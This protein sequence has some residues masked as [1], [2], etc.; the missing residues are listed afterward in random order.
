MKNIVLKFI[1][2]GIQIYLLV[3]MMEKGLPDVITILF[4]TLIVLNTLIM[5]ANVAGITRYIGFPELLIDTT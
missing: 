2:L 4:T 1:E 5:A 3:A